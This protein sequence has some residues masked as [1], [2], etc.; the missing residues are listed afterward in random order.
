MIT[1]IIIGLL[2]SV[3]GLLKCNGKL[4]NVI[5]L[6]WIT[7][8]IISGIHYLNLFNLQI[9]Y[10]AILALCSV[11]C[12]YFFYVNKTKKYKLVSVIFLILVLSIIRDLFGLSYYY[13]FLIFQLI[14]TV[15]ILIYAIIDSLKERFY[16]I[17]LIL[18]IYIIN[19]FVDKNIIPF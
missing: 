14:V 13:E 12:G 5:F 19:E 15:P 17:L 4:E 8:F 9:V 10:Y 7:L 16:L 1:L 2:S 3:L 18:L 6:L 11:L